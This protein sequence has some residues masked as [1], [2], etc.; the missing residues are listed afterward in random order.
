MARLYAI[1]DIHG[2]R[3]MLREAHARI[4]ADREEQGDQTSL[5]VHLGD[6]CDRGPDAR[7]VIDDL[8]SGI[9]AGEPWHVI[10]GNHDQLFLD[11]LEATGPDDP[12]YSTA[13]MWLRNNIGALETLRSY[14]VDSKDLDFEEVQEAALAAVPTPHLAFLR[15][16][17]FFF[18]TL[19]LLCVHAG[20]RPGVPLMQQ[21]KEDL[22]W[23]REDFLNN[24]RD[25]GRL[26]VHGHTPAEFPENWGNRVNLDTGAGF[27]RP[28]TA[29][30]FEGRECY[31]LTDE[32]REH[33]P[34]LL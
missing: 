21:Y 24:R 19:D 9:A 8:M 17:P 26:I 32:G 10:R 33:L 3:T 29:A 15:G 14:G 31:V 16:L 30:V 22:I 18:E 27:N 5:V 11:F 23:I 13:E 7:G 1:G 4:A 28:M 6:L 34:P 2:Q 20:I 25:H 12:R